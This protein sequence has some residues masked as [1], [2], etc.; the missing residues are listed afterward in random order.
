MTSRS[1]ISAFPCRSIYNGLVD[2]AEAC[3]F[4]NAPPWK[5]VGSTVRVERE[6]LLGEATEG[7]DY[8]NT[9]EKNCRVRK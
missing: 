1:H 6:L 3:L 9:G 5:S 8:E 4:V 2:E 7:L